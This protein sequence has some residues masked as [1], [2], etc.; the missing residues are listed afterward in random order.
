MNKKD[1]I[2]IANAYMLI[3]EGING[4]YAKGDTASSEEISSIDNF[5]QN[6]LMNYA[7]SKAVPDEFR[8][9][10][11][12]WNNVKVTPRNYDQAYSLIMTIGSTVSQ[13]ELGQMI[14]DFSNHFRKR[15]GKQS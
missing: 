8:R 12:S 6:V 4:G 3:R 13:S 7:F 2:A 11:Q 15:Y 10:L 1:Q 9:D 5:L 14:S